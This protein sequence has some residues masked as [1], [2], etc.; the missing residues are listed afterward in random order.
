[1]IWKKCAPNYNRITAR[2]Q[3]YAAHQKF[4]ETRP[5]QPLN[6]PEMDELASKK[7][8]EDDIYHFIIFRA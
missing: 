2:C 7:L 6:V 1:M 8:S 4:N 3:F 5:A